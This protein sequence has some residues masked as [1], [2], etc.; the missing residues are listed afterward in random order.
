MENQ[1]EILALFNSLSIEAQSHLLDELMQEHELQTPILESAKAEVATERKP[2]PHCQS[3]NVYKR[4]I[5][6]GMQMYNCKD[7]KRWYSQST[8]TPLWHL[9]SKQ[10][11]VSYIRC[12]NENY[13]LRKSAKEAGVCLQTSFIWRHKILSSLKSLA[14]K[15]L[16]NTVEC[17]E[18]ELAINNKG[19]RDLSRQARKRGS[20]F[21]RNESDEVSVVQVITAVERS[22]NNEK[23]DKILVAVESKRLSEAQIA[24][25]LDGKIDKAT[26]LITDKHPSY[27]A[28]A[29]QRPQIIHKMVLAKDHVDKNDRNSHLQTVN[30]THTQLRKFLAH[31]NGVGTKYLQ[32]Y[33]NW[34]AY[35]GKIQQA[36]KVIKQWIITALK[37]HNAYALFLKYQQ[38]AVIIRT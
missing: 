28:F 38:N 24:S 4:G 2:C 36:K 25:A 3:S 23:G 37:D 8:G 15:T 6:N 22:A 5:Q 19:D 18:L 32:N 35:Q 7:C 20:D 16:S 13:S 21:S 29:K 30:N 26:T 31:F 1:H 9:H 14:P 33:L 10:K 12:M 27:K 17:D 34:F 11:W